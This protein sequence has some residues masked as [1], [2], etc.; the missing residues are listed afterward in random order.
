MPGYSLVLL[1][2]LYLFWLH[3]IYDIVCAHMKSIFFSFFGFGILC[4]SYQLSL[5]L[6]SSMLSKSIGL[7]LCSGLFERM[8]NDSSFLM[9]FSTVAKFQKQ[10]CPNQSGLHN[11]S[12]FPSIFGSN[13]DQ[14]YSFSSRGDLYRLFS[15]SESFKRQSLSTTSNLFW[16]LSRRLTCAC[17]TEAMGVRSYLQ[18]SSTGLQL[19]FLSLK[20][21]LKSYILII[22]LKVKCS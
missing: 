5:S 4:S 19:T 15:A 16:S 9:F 17:N 7:F 20:V 3:I 1:G 21:Q 11:Q 8:G 12:I 22:F 10:N 13:A 14:S 2:W 6:R 18:T